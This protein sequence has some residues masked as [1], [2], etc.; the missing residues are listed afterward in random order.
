MPD[1]SAPDSAL[2]S[3]STLPPVLNA[4]WQTLLADL[5]QIAAQHPDALLACSMGIEDTLL[6][7]ALM[8]LPQR[9]GI[10]M[11]D[12]GRL[13]AETL[14][15]AA[16][17]EQRYGIQ[18]ERVQPQAQAV[19]TYVLTHGAN[20]FYD[21]VALRQ[22]C[23]DIRKVTPLRRVLAGR[24]AWI[25]GQRREQAVTRTELPQSQWDEGFGLHKYNPLALWTTEDVWAVAQALDVPS[26]PLHQR[27]YPS[28]GCEPCTRAVRP[29]EDLRA[30]RWWWEQRDSREC[31]LHVSTSAH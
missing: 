19:Q 4:L 21:S 7:H 13:H 22:S 2:A 8:Q 15:L 24:S 9:L 6:T 26:H 10:F 28:I 29:G 1:V 17:I 14:A 18:I 20:A 30:G 25:T 31:G 27:G 12:T 5:S 3:S 16:T 23:C 11:L